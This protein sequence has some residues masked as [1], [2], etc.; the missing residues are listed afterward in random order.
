MKNIN[1]ATLGAVSPIYNM[2]AMYLILEIICHMDDMC[3]N[4]CMFQL[5]ATYQMCS[6]SHKD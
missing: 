5:A 6:Q 2:R 3:P 1:A 4:F